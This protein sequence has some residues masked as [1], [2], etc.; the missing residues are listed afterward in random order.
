MAFDPTRLL[1]DSTLGIWQFGDSAPEGQRLLEARRR[2]AGVARGRSITSHFGSQLV[3]SGINLGPGKG[4]P[5]AL[6]HYD[7]VAEGAAQRGDVGLQGLGG[8]ARRIIAPQQL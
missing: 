8:G 5:R 1:G 4:P 2:L 3:P 7:A 6:G